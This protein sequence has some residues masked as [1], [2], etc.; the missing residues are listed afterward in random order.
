[1]RWPWTG[2]PPADTEVRRRLLRLTLAHALEAPFY[3]RAWGTRWRKG[4]AALPVLTK[5]VA[6]AY[7]HDLLVGARAPFVGVVSSG[8][9][10]GDRTPLHVPE[11]EAERAAVADFVAARFGDGETSGGGLHLEVLSMQHGFPEGPPP[12]G[13]L[14]VPWAFSANTFH[15]LEAL[16]FQPQRGR[17]RVE[18][19][20]IGAAALVPLT[21][22]LY[23]Q[24]RDFS[25]LRVRAIGTTGFRLGPH[26][27]ARVEALWGARVYDNFSLSELP[28]AAPSCE[29]C[30]FHHF[31]LPAVVSEI[32]DPFT[33]R[34]L[35]RGVGV[36]VVT[37]LWPFVQAMPLVRYWTGD[38]VALGPR[39]PQRAERGFRFLGRHSQCA[40]V[41]GPDGPQLLASP[42]D[43]EAFLDGRPEVS[44]LPHPAVQLGLVKSCD[45]GVPRFELEWEGARRLRLTVRVE[46]RFDPGVFPAQAHA[47]EAGLTDALQRA[48]PGLRRALRQGR[49]TLRV[50]LAR[51]NTLTRPWSKF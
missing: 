5:D 10:H 6:V 33:R 29:A 38:L 45:V 49:A 15:V 13:V 37:T 12:P 14:R 23:E 35:S 40:V 46:V 26:W 21:A 7:Q 3:R 16:L 2:A 48:S 39:C 22:W 41:P 43:V 25:R 34:P 31:E 8:T 47:L 18:S 42:Q 51:P 50:A 36:L 4:L 27:R 20:V 19:L 32:L 44:R 28:V 24:G 17:R 1:M 9:Q 30:G 11:T